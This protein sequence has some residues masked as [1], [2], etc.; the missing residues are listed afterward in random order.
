[1]SESKTRSQSRP[2]EQAQI[3]STTEFIRAMRRAER[4]RVCVERPS[5]EIAI[6][7]L[8]DVEN[9]NALGG[10]LTVQ[11]HSRLSEL[12]VDPG[13]RVIVLTGSGGVFSVGGDW[14]LMTAFAHKYG[15]RDEGTTGLWLWIRNQFGGI[16]RMITQSDKVVVAAINGDAAGVAL[17]WA[18]NADLIA[19]AEDARLV[20]AFGRIGLVPEVGTNWVLTRRLGHA[21]AFELFLTGRPLTGREAADIGLINTAVPAAELDGV[22]ERWC[23]AVCRLPE[24]VVTMTKPLMRAA[25]DM[26]WQHA[27][28]AEEFAEPN[29]FTTRAHREAVE[30]LVGKREKALGES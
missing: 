17:A 29:T 7:R 30:A 26:S 19:A 13:L 16:A 8:D 18:L 2:E 12:V 14:K 28:V 6:V 5:E 25:A 3:G 15:E 10:E 24:H 22:V 20:T 11:L 4:R 1:M 21:R 9:M 27:I 23:Q